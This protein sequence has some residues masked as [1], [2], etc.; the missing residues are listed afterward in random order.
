MQGT[1]RKQ[2]TEYSPKDIVNIKDAARKA[3]LKF[4]GS[5]VVSSVDGSELVR[6]PANANKQSQ[7]W[8]PKYTIT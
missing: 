1:K 7:V 4:H 2:T 5:S 3:T 8:P 6:L